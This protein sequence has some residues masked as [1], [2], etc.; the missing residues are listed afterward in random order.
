MQPLVLLAV[1]HFNS[2]SSSW[3]FKA[4]FLYLCIYKSLLCFLRTPPPLRQTPSYALLVRTLEGFFQGAACASAP[5]AKPAI[6]SLK[7]YGWCGQGTKERRKQGDLPSRSSIPLELQSPFPL[8]QRPNPTRLPG[9]ILRIA[10]ASAP[11]AKPAIFSQEWQSDVLGGVAKEGRRDLPSRSS[12]P[13]QLPSP[14]PLV[15]N[16]QIQLGWWTSF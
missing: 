4:S 12:I 10:R 3:I 11:N 1:R 14:F 6:F 8:G 2:R 16:E 5:N 13:L 7:W 15:H 9:F